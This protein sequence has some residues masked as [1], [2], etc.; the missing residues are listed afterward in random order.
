MK[1]FDSLNF[2]LKK[3]Q[4]DIKKEFNFQTGS[5]VAQFD[6]KIFSPKKIVKK[7]TISLALI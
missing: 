5:G 4:S 6:L 2:K 7:F 1:S 3:I